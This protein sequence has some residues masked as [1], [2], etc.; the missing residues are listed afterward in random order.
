MNV[1]AFLV[2][3]KTNPLTYTIKKLS[4]NSENIILLHVDK[5]SNIL[6]F[7]DFFNYENVIFIK[8]RVDCFWGDISLVDATIN[9]MKTSLDYNYNYFSLLS[10]D[11]V[12]IESEKN[13]TNF[14]KE[15]TDQFI[16]YVPKINSKILDRVKFNYSKSFFIKNDKKNNLQKI[17]TKYTLIKHKLNIGRNKYF[18]CIPTVYK[19]TQWFSL[20]RH[21]IELILLYI[22]ENKM[23]HL[24]FKKSFAPDELFFHII[25]KEL[26][27]KISEEQQSTENTLRA[28]R[29]IDWISGPDFPKTLNQSD[30]FHVKNSKCFFARKFEP[31]IDM[32]VLC[33]SF[34][35]I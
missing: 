23:Y 7:S 28:L 17:S 19:G 12:L 27:L 32:K 34:G 11:D 1:Y 21:A 15:S 22:Q 20:T 24:S 14:F 13:I 30:I 35:E 33:D 25:I 10:G 4:N 18:S 2:H 3:K 8:D 29:Y 6:D 16:A 26:N 31:N 9:L 5:K